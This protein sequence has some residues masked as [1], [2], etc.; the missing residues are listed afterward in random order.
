MR[1]YECELTILMP[2]LNESETLGICIDKARTFLERS[3]VSGEI[4]IADNGSTDGS[5]DIAISKG[6][7][8]VNIDTKGYGAAL[9]GGCN[10][11]HGRY[12]IMGDSDDSY[13]F[14]DLMPFVEKLR[15]GYDLVMGNR[16]KGGI[17]KGAMPFSHKYIGNPVLSFLGR[18]FYG[19]RIGDFHC[20][21]RGYNT[22]RMRALGLKTTGME[23]AS[24]MVVKATLSDYRIVEVPTTLR[25]DGR[26]H[27][28]HLNTW[29]DGWRHLKFLLMHSPKWLFLYPGLVLSLIGLVCMVLL[30]IGPVKIGSV[31][32][33]IQTLLYSSAFLLL[34]VNMVLFSQYTETYART[35]GFIPMKPEKG[36]QKLF[37][38]ERGIILGVLLLIAGIVCSILAVTVWSKFSYGELNPNRTMRLTIPA[39]TAIVLGTEMIF[40]SF[41]IGILKIKHK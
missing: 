29:R 4:L 40:S 15:E 1:D 41:F 26:S 12:V 11:A 25:K 16:F 27:P 24:E 8:V 9:I 36:I 10:S 19:S 6:A 33:D 20:G 37:S 21:L 28:P 35:T 38:V 30:T 18:L 39:F 13:D 3:G 5:L 32:F 22:E 31:T 17:E 2:C 23:Y 14:L 7:R 34:G